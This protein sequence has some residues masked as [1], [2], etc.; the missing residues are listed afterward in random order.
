MDALM[1]IEIA[2]AD[3]HLVAYRARK[4]AIVCAGVYFL[5]AL[6]EALGDETTAASLANERFHAEMA[7]F[8]IQQRLFRLEILTASL[9]RIRFQ[10]RVHSLVHNKIALALKSLA[11]RGATVIKLTCMHSR[12][13]RKTDFTAKC[14][15]AHSALK[16]FFACMLAHVLLQLVIRSI[17]LAAFCALFHGPFASHR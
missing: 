14:F 5:V 12:M 4:L 1:R 9:A 6:A 3:E 7:V 2:L 16:R 13:L 17:L 8:V 10:I 15:S 11:T